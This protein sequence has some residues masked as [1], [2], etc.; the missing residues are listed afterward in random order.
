MLPFCFLSCSF[1]SS[2][3]AASSA[4]AR[5]AEAAPARDATEAEARAALSCAAREALLS[6]V[7]FFLQ[8]DQRD[9]EMKSK[10]HRCP[11]F[12]LLSPSLFRLV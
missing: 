10:H 7:F 6:L 3:S 5:A 4:A 2:S 12:P 9:C 11:A 8:Q 1:W